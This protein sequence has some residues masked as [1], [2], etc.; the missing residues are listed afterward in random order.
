[1]GAHARRAAAS[2]P[3][4]DPNHAGRLGRTA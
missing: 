3:R 2:P 4:S 1:M